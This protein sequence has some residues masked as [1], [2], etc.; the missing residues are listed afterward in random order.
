VFE[1]ETKDITIHS[2]KNAKEEVWFTI[3]EILH[4]VREE[5][6]RYREIAVVTGDIG[7]YG[8]IVEQEY[9]KAGIPCFL[10]N[11]RAIT[12]NPYVKLLNGFLELFI[13]PSMYIF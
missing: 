12:A 6:L 8:R 10:D 5:G 1:E 11:K 7:S 9:A 2:L 4:L 3:R 13:I